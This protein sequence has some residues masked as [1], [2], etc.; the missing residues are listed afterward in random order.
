M[1]MEAVIQERVSLEN[2]LASLRTQIHNFE[3]EVEEQKIK[4]SIAFILVCSCSLQNNL[5]PYSSTLQVA[6][7]RT[8]HDRVH[9]ELNSVRLKMKECDKEISVIM[10]EHKMLEHKLSE[11]NLERK[12]VENEVRF[13]KIYFY[14][15]IR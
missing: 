1:E 13:S 5:S 4:A 10:K 6:A 11:N 3:A 9:S 2:Q 15:K 8:D 12:R 14:I 7:A